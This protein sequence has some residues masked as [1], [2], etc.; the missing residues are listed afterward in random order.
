MNIIEVLLVP[1]WPTSK[2]I[3][4][5]NINSGLHLLQRENLIYR[6]NKIN[7]Q[8]LKNERNLIESTPNKVVIDFISMREIFDKNLQWQSQRIFGFTGLVASFSL[9]K[10]RKERICY[11]LNKTWC[12]TFSSSGLQVNKF[13][14]TLMWKTVVFQKSLVSIFRSL[15]FILLAIKINKIPEIE[16]KDL[17][18]YIPNLLNGHISNSKS[19][20]DFTL[21]N[22]LQTSKFPSK[23][24]RIFHSNI[25]FFINP[26]MKDYRN[27]VYINLNWRWTEGIIKDILFRIVLFSRLVGRLLVDKN[28][29]ILLL[30]C[31]DILQ[32]EYL[33]IKFPHDLLNISIFDQSMIISKPLWADCLEKQRMSNILLFY[34]IAAEPAWKN[35]ET[36][37]LAQWQATKWSEYWVIDEILKDK[38]QEIKPNKDSKFKIVGVPYWV[39]THYEIQNS[40][41]NLALFDSEPQKNLFYISN[42][43]EMGIYKEDFYQAF[44][45]EILERAKFYDFKILHK[46]KRDSVNKIEE[47]YKELLNE[48]RAKYKDHYSEVDHLISPHKILRNSLASISQPISTVG[49]ISQELKIP[50]IFYDPESKINVQEKELRGVHLVNSGKKLDDWFDMLRLKKG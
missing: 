28:R 20:N 49:I 13:V 33:G 37:S 26:K 43:I 40:K 44:F 4:K 7:Q 8:I 9:A 46:G 24:L 1:F 39:D 6:I 50:T 45:R 15:I 2:F 34:A 21:V 42:L 31:F 17:N 14:S 38:I 3:Q 18:I 36:F 23:N 41:Q 16:K 10:E 29:N 47:F 35:G 32:A 27:P 5:K 19:K 48:I 30:H 25:N 11:P 22:W 12:E